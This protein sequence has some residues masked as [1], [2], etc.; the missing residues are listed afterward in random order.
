VK[1]QQQVVYLRSRSLPVLAL[2]L[3]YARVIGSRPQARTP[4]LKPVGKQLRLEGI[5]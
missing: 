4:R 2:A 5:R 1:R 3:A